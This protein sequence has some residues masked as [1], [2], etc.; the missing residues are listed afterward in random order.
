MLRDKV[1]LALG[2]SH[3]KLDSDIDET[4]SSAMSEME[5]IGIFAEKVVDTDPLIVEAIKTY[6]KYIYYT[7]LDA[8]EKFFESWNYQ[9]DCLRKSSDY[10]EPVVEVVEETSEV[11]IG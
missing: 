9:I 4:I 5:R 8:R 2:I 1:K 6:C 11:V 7:E 3:S 10:Q